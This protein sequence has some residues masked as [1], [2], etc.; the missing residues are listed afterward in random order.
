MSRFLLWEHTTK[1]AW[2]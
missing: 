2:R 1:S